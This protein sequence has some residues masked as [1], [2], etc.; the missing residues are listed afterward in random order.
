MKTTEIKI[1]MEP[2]ELLR[3]LQAKR[4]KVLFK[5][6]AYLRTTMQRSMRYATKGKKSAPGEPPRAHRDNPRGPLLRKLVSFAVDPEAG[7]VICGPKMTQSQS[8]PVPKLLNEGGRVPQKRLLKIGYTLGE[9]GPIR[10]TGG[11]KYQGTQLVTAAQVDRAN[12]LA[13][14]INQLRTSGIGAEIKSRPFTAPVMSDGGANF[15]KLLKS[16]PL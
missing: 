11:G 8:P 6:G 14:E 16:V 7:S 15:R 5:Q 4:V 9:G 2:R 10:L 13:L 1:T 3:R 12:R